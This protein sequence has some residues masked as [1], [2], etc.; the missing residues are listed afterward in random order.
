M[1]VCSVATRDTAVLENVITNMATLFHPPT[2]LPPLK[3]DEN[4]N[5]KPSD[6]NVIVMAPK[7]DQQ[8]QRTRKK[9]KLSIRPQPESNVADFLREFSNHN[10]REVLECPDANFKTVNFNILITK[11]QHYGVRN[12]EQYIHNI[13]LC[14]VKILINVK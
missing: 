7:S 8:F 2:T 9:R 5:G 13:V 3:Q 10:W 4:K 11:M 1:Q 14:S 6:H 12:T